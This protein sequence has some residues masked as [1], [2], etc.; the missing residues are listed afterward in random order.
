MPYGTIFFEIVIKGTAGIPLNA[1][2]VGM[3]ARPV[4][5]H[6]DR[7]LND[8]PI[9]QISLDAATKLFYSQNEREIGASRRYPNPKS[10][11]SGDRFMSHENLN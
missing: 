4:A 10:T 1:Q 5:A 2:L 8:V 6:I 3:Q 11:S 7:E 9:G